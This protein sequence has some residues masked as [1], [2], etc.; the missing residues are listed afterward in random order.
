MNLIQYKYDQNADKGG[1]VKNSENFAD[2]INGC[3]L[4]HGASLL[5]VDWKKTLSR[6]RV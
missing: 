4:K 2:D 3:S 5:T 6:L 1:G